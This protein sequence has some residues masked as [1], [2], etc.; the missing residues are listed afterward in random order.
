LAYLEAVKP[1]TVRTNEI[2][3]P[4]RAEGRDCGTRA[5]LLPRKDP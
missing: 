1:I 2:F 4:Y 5:G 3:A